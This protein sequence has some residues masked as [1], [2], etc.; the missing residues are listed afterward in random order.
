MITNQRYSDKNK[1]T[2]GQ[3]DLETFGLTKQVVYIQ[4][5]LQTKKTEDDAVCFAKEAPSLTLI[6]SFYYLWQ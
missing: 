2:L 4:T 6:R 5:W 1:L 3:P